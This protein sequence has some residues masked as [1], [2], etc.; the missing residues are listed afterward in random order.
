MTEFEQEL[1]WLVF[2]AQRD[3]GETD[4]D[5]QE[6]KQRAWNKAKQLA[7]EQPQKFGLMP[8]ALTNAM[9]ANA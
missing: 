8:Q 4:Q 7:R 2:I 5:H 9:R 6:N 3:S 1:S